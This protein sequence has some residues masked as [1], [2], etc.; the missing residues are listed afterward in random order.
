MVYKFC[1]MKVVIIK[2]K[3]ER[4][5]LQTEKEQ[6]QI[7]SLYQ[8]NYVP[9]AVFVL[10]KISQVENN[11]R[12]KILPRGLFSHQEL[13]LVDVPERNART[14]RHCAKRVVRYVN[15]KFCFL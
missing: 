9:H 13:E 2:K 14:P 15:G 6:E 1:T 8:C 3:H 5:Y 12:R 4:H 7:K 10:K 11:A